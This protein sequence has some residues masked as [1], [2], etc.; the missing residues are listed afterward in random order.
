MIFDLDQCKSLKQK[1][2]PVY[3]QVRA[4]KG[5]GGLSFNL[6]KCQPYHVSRKHCS[7]CAQLTRAKP[8]PTPRQPQNKDMTREA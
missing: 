3:N 2:E 1:H 6:Y 7:T 4:G 5:E 8:R